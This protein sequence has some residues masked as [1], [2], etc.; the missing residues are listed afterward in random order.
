VLTDCAHRRGRVPFAID[1]MLQTPDDKQTW[2]TP[3]EIAARGGAA[4]CA[5]VA[6]GWQ[7]GGTPA[8]LARAN[9]ATEG[10]SLAELP[11]CR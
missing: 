8:S 2:R 5:L 7:A 6:E 4:A 3:F 10:H 9:H 11:E 1:V